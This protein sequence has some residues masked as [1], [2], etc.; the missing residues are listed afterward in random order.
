MNV[1]VSIAGKL[2]L[3]ANLAELAR[4]VG[5]DR[6][7][8]FVN[9][10]RVLSFTRAIVASTDEPPPAQLIVAGSI[11]AKSALFRWKLL[12]LTPDQLSSSHKGVVDRP[13][14]RLP[15]QRG[16]NAIK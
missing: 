2:V 14:Q 9:E 8:A 10:F 11:E 13:S 15:A 6:G 7:E 16:V 12:P 5:K 1:E 4:P 3:S